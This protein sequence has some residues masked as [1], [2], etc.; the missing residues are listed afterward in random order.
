M[1]SLFV[2]KH[3]TTEILQLSG[4]DADSAQLEQKRG[5]RCD[6]AHFAHITL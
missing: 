1:N 3:N 2:A 5:L 6:E 4:T